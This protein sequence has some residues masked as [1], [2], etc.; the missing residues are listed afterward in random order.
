MEWLLFLLGGGGAALAGRYLWD[1]RGARRLDAA[2]LAQIRKVADEDVTEFGEELSRLDVVVAG[3]ELDVDTRHDYQ[4][5]LDSYESAGRRV[6]H[7]HTPDAISAVVDALAEGRYALSCVRARVTGQAVPERR[8]PCF[9]NPQHG[10]SVLDVQWTPASG[11]TRRVPAC[12]QCAA[13]L[14]AGDEPAVRY[15]KYGAQRVPYWEAGALIE[16]YSLGYFGSSSIARA[17]VM[18]LSMELRGEGGGRWGNEP[19]KDNSKSPG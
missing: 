17:T 13:R 2:E 5:A 11:G 18:A 1:R 14:K 12:T 16:P 8:S 7:L 19:E 10:P 15:V 3:R 4:R 9:F 6:A